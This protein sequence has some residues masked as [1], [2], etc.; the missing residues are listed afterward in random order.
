MKSPRAALSVSQRIRAILRRGRARGVTL[1]EVLMAVALVS[2]MTGVAVLGTGVVESARLKRSAVM[3]A[4]AVRI[5]YGHASASTK[6]VRIVFD[7]GTQTITLEEATGQHLLVKGE[8]SGGA[9]AATEAERAAQE[10]AE[11]EAEGP[12]K[13]RASF[14]P[15]KAM[16]FNPEAGKTG[17]ELDTGVRIVQVETSHDDEPVT[18]DRAYLYFWPGGQ[19]ERAAIVISKGRGSD[20]NEENDVLTV[21]VSPLTGKTEIVRGR[22]EMPKPRN[23]EDESERDEAL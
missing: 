5:A 20:E 12:R 13:S 9:E 14:Q 21:V 23:E 19:T 7:L 15:A 2:L 17:K 22:A 1:I 16:G 6:T 8:R 18:E 10:A 11:A 3:V 4:G